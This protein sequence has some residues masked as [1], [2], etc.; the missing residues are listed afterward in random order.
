MKGSFKKILAVVLVLCML[1]IFPVSVFAE[2]EKS[3]EDYFTDATAFEKTEA[4]GVTTYKLLKDITVGKTCDLF[5]G[6]LDG[7]GKTVTT[8]VPLFAILDS[9][10]VV[11]NLTIAGAINETTNA[12]VGAIS[13][14][15]KESATDVSIKNVTNNAPITV[16]ACND[17]QS[18]GGMVGFFKS[19][20]VKFELC[21]NNGNIT[22]PNGDKGN[23]RPYIG[24]LVGNHEASTVE[25][26]VCTNNGDIT[27]NSVTA[28]I[29][30]YVSGGEKGKVTMVGC[31]NTG[32]ITTVNDGGM[33]AG[34]HYC[35][36]AGLVGALNTGA[37]CTFT[38][39]Y[40][41]GAIKA[42]ITAEND[43]VWTAHAAGLVVTTDAAANRQITIKNSYSGGEVTAVGAG[44]KVAHAALILSEYKRATA[45][46]DAF[47]WTDAKV[48][49]IV[50]ANYVVSDSGCTELANGNPKQDEGVGKPVIDVKLEGHG[51]TF[52]KAQMAD[53]TLTSKL[54]ERFGNKNTVVLGGLF[55]QSDKGYPV[56]VGNVVTK[57]D[58]TFPLDFSMQGIAA[59][60]LHNNELSGLR[61]TMHVNA[62]HYMSLITELF[63]DEAVDVGMLIASKSDVAEAAEFTH[64]AIGEKALAD[65]VVAN[66]DTEAFVYEDSVY[67]VKAVYEP[68]AVADAAV[69][70]CARAYIKI[71]DTYFYSANYTVTSVKTIAKQALADMVEA[72]GDAEQKYVNEV[73]LGA[74]TKYS[75]YTSD[76][77]GL[78]GTY[79]K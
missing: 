8:S 76:E 59:V 23:K 34:Y 32:D 49:N 67:K 68:I 35:T 39:C 74:V 41:A 70:Y 37:G 21:V 73:T 24:G 56:Y 22:M 44:E 18:V 13:R 30:G 54:N 60:K 50:A 33:T 63:T 7:N 15:I 5:A 58:K 51:L 27:G 17:K 57:G 69:D 12:H 45:D 25:Y 10:T 53:G 19:A 52:T 14:E 42:Q 2:G 36:A 40:N 3:I 48:D 72:Q 46:T 28:G 26:S 62:P 16:S 66:T 1:P 47:V 77:Q 31:G 64:A 43:K 6:V 61:F 9:G 20:T 79:S 78:L 38:Y 71:G 75:P 55:E 29:A 11:Q 4:D 65:V